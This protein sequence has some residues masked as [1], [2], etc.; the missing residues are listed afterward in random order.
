MPVTGERSQIDGNA[1]TASSFHA[2]ERGLPSLKLLTI[3]G[4][5][6]LAAG[7]LNSRILTGAN[8]AVAVFRHSTWYAVWPVLGALAVVLFSSSFR[9]RP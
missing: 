5:A 6:G 7:W 8:E 9:I 2:Q 4:V 1:S 3:I